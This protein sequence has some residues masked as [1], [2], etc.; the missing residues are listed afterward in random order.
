MVL[1]GFNYAKEC[2]VCDGWGYVKHDV[3]NQCNLCKGSGIN[4][5]QAVLIDRGL[6]KYSDKELRELFLKEKKKDE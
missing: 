4:P 6:D 5:T 2:I 3:R 1:K